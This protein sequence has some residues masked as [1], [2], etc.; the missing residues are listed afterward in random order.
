[1]S[2]LRAKKRRQAQLESLEARRV[3]AAP[4]TLSVTPDNATVNTNAPV[5]ITGRFQDADG[6]QDLRLAEFRVSDSFFSAPRCFV[7]Y[8]QNTDLLKLYDDG[9][10]LTA[11]TLGSAGTA[12]AANCSVNAAN[13]SINVI[14]ANTVDVTIEVTFFDG[15]QGS[16]N[17]WLRPFEDAGNWGAMVDHGDITIVPG[18]DT[19][20]PAAP[21]GLVATP[22]DSEITLDWADNTEGD[23]VGYNIYRSQTSGSGYALLNTSGPIA[24]S[25]FVDTGLTNGTPYYYVVQAV[26]LASN[27]STDS[28]E[29]TATPA[30]STLP[31]TLDVTPDNA[32]V[33]TGVPIQI[34]GRFADANGSADIRLAE[35]RVTDSF[36]ASPRCLVRYD[37]NTDL[38]K[39]FDGSS[40]LTA[41]NPGSGGSVSSTDCT[42]NAANSS[43]TTVDSTTLDVEVDL[44]FLSP[45]EGTRN[46]WL[47]GFEQ[48]G[49]WGDMTIHT[50]IDIGASVDTT[51]P[52][53]PTAL[54][55][56]AGDTQVTLDW[57]DNGE[58]DLDGYDVYR[59]TT[60]GGA[61]TKINSTLVTA[62]NYVDTGL[63]N[64]TPYYYVVQAVDTSNNAS[65]NSSEATATPSG[66]TPS[67]TITWFAPPIGVATP[68]P[69]AGVAGSGIPAG[70]SM[71]VRHFDFGSSSIV[72]GNYTPVSLNDTQT[73]DGD[74][75]WSPAGNNAYTQPGTNS[76]ITLRVDFVETGNTSNTVAVNGH[77]FVLALLDFDGDTSPANELIDIRASGV[78]S[79][80]SLGVDYV[81]DP[82]YSAAANSAEFIE[83]GDEAIST[84]QF[85][86][87]NDPS[88]GEVNNSILFDR[89]IHGH[90]LSRFFVTT[91]G[92]ASDDTHYIRFGF[93]DNPSIVF[94][95]GQTPAAPTGL[96]ATAG[97]GEVSLDWNDSLEA[98]VNSYKIYRGTAM[99]GPY[100][101]IGTTTVDSTAEPPINDSEFVDSTAV[102]GTTYYYVVTANTDSGVESPDST[103][104]MATP[105]GSSG[106]SLP[107][108]ISITPDTPTV[109]V[110]TAIELTGRLEDLNGWEDLRL[111]EMRVADSF[112]SAPRCLVRYDQ[113][114][115]LIKLFDGT[116]FLTVGAP[117]SAGTASTS[118][119]SVNAANSSVTPIDANTVDVTF[120]ITF[121]AGLQGTRNLWLRGF[122]D[123]LAWGAS[124]D[125]GD[126]TIN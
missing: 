81:V 14:D 40:F 101:E 52:A 105:S 83:T 10:F 45:L 29:A 58:S 20:P 107:S 15:L 109:A 6:W 43:V 98:D 93:T 39:L 63:S 37:Q 1:M 7:R 99:G 120:E 84:T 62:S 35:F 18:S 74:Y 51:P 82:G 108:A 42:L 68:V 12:T 94:T 38:L 26:D 2:S 16:R 61:Y 34:T 126:I 32:S 55:A 67:E 60:S 123:S 112:F 113:N 89:N 9:P 56:T 72:S 65:G 125:L 91:N 50:T 17:L 116:T 79:P 88:G 46:I 115:D 30:A 86:T 73:A 3:L 124:A 5:Q 66:G 19:T 119:C 117:G 57:A 95:P 114:T 97:D 85:L 27:S 22:G 111:A 11:G 48:A 21:T 13:S 102:N 70:T 100:S 110:G 47:R 104:V 8:D 121:A 53:A 59:S 23:L 36:F 118:E 106:P 122:E 4:T 41:G 92:I 103:E 69:G 28:A 87:Y 33:N 54:V 25:D 75:G 76:D 77:A 49:N 80:G 96:A 71:I 78:V 90:H 44:T 64:G 24:T 31:T